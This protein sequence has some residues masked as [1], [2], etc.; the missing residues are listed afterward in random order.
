[1]LNAH[2]KLTEF[3]LSSGTIY[4]LFFTCF[5]LL[6]GL[7]SIEAQDNSPYSRYGLGN[8]NPNTNIFNRGMAGISAGYS[9]Q[10]SENFDNPAVASIYPTI[11]FRNPASYSRFYMKKEERSNKSEYGRVLLDMGINFDNRTLR[12]PNNPIRFTSSNG[13]FSYVQLGVPIKRN[14]GFVMGLRPLTKISYKIERRERLYDPNTN[15]PI[16]SAMTEFNGDGGAYLL[17]TGT[18]FAFGNLSL[19]VNAGYMFGKK[20]Y[21]TRRTFINDTVAYSRSNHETLSTF[22][23]VYFEGGI[24]YRIDLNKTKTKYLQLGAFGNLEQKITTKTDFIRETYT[25]F[26]DNG[27]YR[28]DSVS[29]QL[30][31]KNTMIYPSSFG[32]GFVYEK[33]ADVNNVGW[34]FGVDYIKTNWD[35][36]RFNGLKDSVRSN[37]QLRIGGQ[38]R[39][40]LKQAKYKNFVTYRAGVYFG[41]DYIYL[42]NKIPELGITAGITLP[43]ANLKDPTRRFRTQYTVI[44]IAAE[45]IKRGNNNNSLRENMFRISVGFSLSDIWFTKRKYD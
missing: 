10:P 22:G 33:L 15:L 26:P 30:G 29:E 2:R 12:E 35:N 32:A 11:N 9:D 19:G 13:Y 4:T 41:E 21:S 24:Q 42:N 38:I 3:S 36:Y 14:W 8:I 34:L 23:N 39:P 5:L 18:G 45:Y 7:N 37:W 17:H 44:N 16:D 6:T 25:K 1:M 27:D 28:L 43:V 31:V 20:D 40:S